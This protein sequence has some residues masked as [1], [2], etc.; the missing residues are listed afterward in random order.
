LGFVVADSL[1]RKF[2]K[3][4]EGELSRLRA[5]LVKGVSLAVI[6]KKLGL[7][8][9]L[10]LGPGEMKSGGHRRDSIL[11]DALESIIGAIYLDGGIDHARDFIDRWFCNQLENLS[12]SDAKKD[13]KTQLQE[14]LQSRKLALPQYE[15]ISTAGEMHDP[16]FEVK[17]SV[18]V[19]KNENLT[20][21]ETAKSRRIAEQKAASNML[22]ILQIK[23]LK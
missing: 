21:T 1:Y 3:A 15:V 6:A 16:K 12:V 13:P 14:L 20:C 23:G 19:F 9:F 17:C 4:A 2:P 8:E 5:K 10:I 18:V 22:Q 11:A 7:G